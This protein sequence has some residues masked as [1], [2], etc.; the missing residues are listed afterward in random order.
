[1]ITLKRAFEVFISRRETYCSEKT[2][3]NYKNN[4]RYFID[5]MMNIK[6]KKDDEI[7]ISEITRDDIDSYVIY[8]RHKKKNDNNPVVASSE[9]TITKRSVKTYMT[10]VRTFFNWLVNDE[11]I[12]FNK[13][14][15]Y[16][17]RMI[18]PEVR[19]VIPINKDEMQIIDDGYSSLTT[20]G[21]RNLAILHL[22]IDEGFRISEISKLRIPDVNFD[23]NC[24]LVNGKGS[25]QRILPMAYVVRKYLDRYINQFRPDVVHD[26]VFCDINELPISTDAVKNVISRINNRT[27]IERLHFHL[28]RHTFA[29]SF[30]IGGGSLEVLRIYMGHSDI[31]TTQAYMHIVNA[32][33]FSKNVYQ[34]DPIFFKR[35]Y[36]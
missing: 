21:L 9:K 30:I 4:L 18:K 36:Y 26:Y 13:S 31:K 22:G 23:N 10:D 29:T 20:L 6:Q 27:G 34:L 8:L 19:A 12:E 3:G 32:I 7:L 15:M 11:F 16:K 25:K 33:Q 28:L 24:I 1:M 2:I 5:Y 17:F 14:P 35:I